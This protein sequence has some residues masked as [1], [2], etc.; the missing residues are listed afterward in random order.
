MAD[1]PKFAEMQKMFQGKFVVITEV[2]P[3]IET[4]N[5]NKCECGGC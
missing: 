2:Q 3:V 5:H 1:C 4:N